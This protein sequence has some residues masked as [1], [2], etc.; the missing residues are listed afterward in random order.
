[1]SPDFGDVGKH[2][3]SYQQKER[4]PFL[5]CVTS[6]WR[7][8]QPES[9]FADRLRAMRVQVAVNDGIPVKASLSSK[10]W[11]SAHLNF[12]GDG[13]GD[14]A[15]SLWVQAIDYSD[16][17]NSV[18][19]VW[20]LG[21]LS[22]GDKAEIRVLADGE[23]DPPT[24]VERSTERSTNLF[25]DV[26]QARQLLSAISVCDK[27]L[28]AVLEQSQRAEPE[29]EFKRISQAI[30]GII[31]ELDRTLIQPTLRRHPELLAEAQK[32]RLV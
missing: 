22:V 19:S 14:S 2:E 6:Q 3:L 21:D 31:M 27:E 24:R 23:T 15:G 28:G 8:I 1:M 7:V 16:E 25:S 9:L 30:G 18:N 5:N 17:P 13:T 20:E 4:V 11:L 10:G 32:K 12:S 29:D 26:D